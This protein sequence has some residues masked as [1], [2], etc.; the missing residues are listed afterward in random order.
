MVRLP[1]RVFLTM[2][3]RDLF[4]RVLR[5]SIVLVF[6]VRRV[7]LIVRVLCLFMCVRVILYVCMY[8]C[9]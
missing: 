6:I 8:V 3:L 1:F 5:T 7:R 4:L 9:M 2:C